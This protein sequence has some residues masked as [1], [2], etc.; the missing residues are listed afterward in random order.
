MLKSQNI[1]ISFGS[2]QTSKFHLC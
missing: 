1:S 2:Y